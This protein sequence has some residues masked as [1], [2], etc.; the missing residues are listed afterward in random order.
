M[1]SVGQDTDLENQDPTLAM[2]HLQKTLLISTVLKNSRV[3]NRGL[4]GWLL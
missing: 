2:A 1:G 3:T 4:A